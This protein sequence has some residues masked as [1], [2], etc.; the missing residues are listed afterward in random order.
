MPDRSPQKLRLGDM[1]LDEG[2]IT[3]EQ[4][5]QA[6]SHQKKK[7]ILLGKALVDLSFVSQ[8]VI[9]AFVGTQLGISHVDLDQI[10][11]LPQEALNS[12][13]AKTCVKQQLIPITRKGNRLQLAM[14]DPL[15]MMAIDDIRLTSGC[16][17]DV[18]IATEAS[19]QAAISKYYSAGPVDTSGSD[20]SAEESAAANEDPDDDLHDEDEIEAPDMGEFMESLSGED[21]TGLEVVEDENEDQDISSL[22]AAGEEAPVVKLVAMI[23]TEAIRAG[24]SDIHIEPFEKIMRIRYRIDGVLREKKAPPK[25]L[26]PAIASRIKIMAELDIA[27]RRKPQ[28]GKIRVKMRRK[29]IDL[30]VSTIP[31][32]EGEKIVMRILDA[33][34]INMGIDSLGFLDKPLEIFKSMIA[35]PHGMILVTGPTG[36]GKSTTLYSALKSLNVPGTNICTVEDPVEY[37]VHGMNQVQRKAGVVEFSDA[38]RAF[39]R[40]DPDVILVGEI[41]DKETANI[42]IEAALTGHLV[43]GTLH[44]NSAPEAISRLTNMGVENFMVASTIAMVVGQRLLRRICT[45]CK[46]AYTGSD[47]EWES[48]SVIP[49]EYRRE[50]KSNKTL[51]RGAGCNNCNNGGMKGRLAIHEVMTFNEEIQQLV[52]AGESAVVIKQAVRAMGMLTL[53]EV[54]AI[55]ALEGITTV[56]EMVAHAKED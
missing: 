36:S 40:Q 23:L 54:A 12:V 13:S 2:I 25:A 22:A 16:E 50:D 19:I 43:F 7:G 9:M 47:E 11:D 17:V 24:A 29:E 42:A 35:L 52:V 51:Y 38:L 30:R 14:A 39:L 56:E 48:L 1:L 31:V 53:R 6:M 34:N 55:R 44:T 45:K 4:L 15:N 32:V 21:Q 27:E 33:S 5:Q 18:V 3:N 41:R 37:K 8:D 10:G 26:A 20:L 49:E 46:E 28:D